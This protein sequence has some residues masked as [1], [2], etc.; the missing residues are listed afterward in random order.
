MLLT[1]P[2]AL[3]E[4]DTAAAPAS[5]D[6]AVARPA[7]SDDIA[8]PSADLAH[9]AGE[10]EGFLLIVSDVDDRFA[11]TTPTA[12]LSN[13]SSTK[14]LTLLDDGVAPDAE[15][16][17]SIFTGLLPDPPRGKVSIIL[18][19]AAGI[20]LWT[21]SLPMPKKV[22]QPAVHMIVEGDDFVPAIA[23]QGGDRGTKP[24][25]AT[26][27]AT[28]TATADGVTPLTLP[29][30]TTATSAVQVAQTTVRTG[31]STLVQA[32]L[33]ILL[34]A[35][36]ALGGFM[37]R[38]RQQ[39]VSLLSPLGSRPRPDLP[40]A[41]PSIRGARQIWSVPDSAS[42][43]QVGVAL[44]TRLAGTGPVV[45]APMP[46]H[47][48]SYAQALGNQI[49]VAWLREQRVEIAMLLQGAPCLKSFG[50]VTIIV[51]G[52]GALEEAGG[53]EPINAVVADLLDCPSDDMDLLILVCAEEAKNLDVSLHLVKV[54]GGLG[55]A[56]TA[57]FKTSGSRLSL[58]D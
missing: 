32:V 7:P 31:H 38:T 43:A 45:I 39:T 44:T 17:D 34:L 2:S 24:T 54:E 5:E 46:E 13:K 9:N 40:S 19:D 53:D 30:A 37:V 22:K 51:E 4:G 56:G 58:A 48:E 50:R 47:R 1:L 29:S 12:Q 27:T 8:P 55:T 16:E 28:A 11:G 20:D 10:M 15:A 42:M 21:D 33:C 57:I 18:T 6:E 14:T 25:A 3:A 23:T 52:V 49:G 36:G 26:A 35:A 41:L